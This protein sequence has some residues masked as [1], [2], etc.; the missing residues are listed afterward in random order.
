MSQEMSNRYR[1]GKVFFRHLTVCCPSVFQLGCKRL[2]FRSNSSGNTKSLDTGKKYEDG[3]CR[4]RKV[5]SPNHIFTTYFAIFLAS[6]SAQSLHMPLPLSSTQK[7]LVNTSTSTT[8][9]TSA[10]PS[11]QN[12]YPK[13]YPFPIQCATFIPGIGCHLGQRQSYSPDPALHT[14]KLP[15]SKRSSDFS[16]TEMKNDDSKTLVVSNRGCRLPGGQR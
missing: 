7:L 14:A 16:L 6:P 10:L 8:C 2:G 3:N 15:I 5:C 1:I 9:F 13:W 4:G 12:V 11:S